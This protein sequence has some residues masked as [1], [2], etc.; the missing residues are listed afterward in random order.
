MP[1]G[2]II[3]VTSSNM[4]CYNRG[5][6]PLASTSLRFKEVSEAWV[7][8][9]NPDLLPNFSIWLT[10]IYQAVLKMAGFAAAP[11]RRGHPRKANSLSW[12]GVMPRSRAQSVEHKNRFC[13]FCQIGMPRR[14]T[15]TKAA[16]M[17]SVP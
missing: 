7:V 10:V 13:C 11:G 1:P 8:S 2:K 6:T 9:G 5:S 12:S 4:S 15:V 3:L 14:C 17:T 16:A